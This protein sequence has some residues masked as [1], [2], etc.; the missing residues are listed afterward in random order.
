M[1][2]TQ[3]IQCRGTS[4]IPGWGTKILHAMWPKIHIYMCVCVCVCVCI[5]IY[6]Y[7]YI[8]TGSKKKIQ[9]RERCVQ[10]V[11]FCVKGELEYTYIS[12]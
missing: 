5:Y 4:L 6:I 1:V 2:K 12:L 9:H 7:I 3:H 10:Y 11:T 8:Y